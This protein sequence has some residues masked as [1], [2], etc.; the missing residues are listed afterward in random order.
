MISTQTVK[1]VQKRVLDTGVSIQRE[2]KRSRQQGYKE[3]D[4]GCSVS[5]FK[6]PV[7]GVGEPASKKGLY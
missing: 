1:D 4:T 5:V 6:T 3:V 2:E 7:S